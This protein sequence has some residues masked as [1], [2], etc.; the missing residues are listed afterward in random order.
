MPARKVTIKRP[1]PSL[2][3][4]QARRKW[5]H[6]HLR[7]NICNWELVHCS[8]ES[9]ILL[10]PVDGGV[11]I[12]WHKTA[13]FRGVYRLVRQLLRKRVVIYTTE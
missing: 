4:R 6:D 5:S 12:W 1:Q 7:W 3:D 8:D 13:T 10:R 9:R 11:R 2:R